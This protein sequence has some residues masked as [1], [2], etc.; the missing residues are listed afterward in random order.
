[1][2][3]APDKD[4]PLNPFPHYR[5]MRESA[6]VFHDEQSGSWHVFRYDDVQRVL[7]EH[8]LFSSRMGGD[9]PSETGQLFAASLISTDPPRHRQLRSLV[10]QA[11]TP[12]AVEALAPRIS[13][14]TEELL[15]GIASTGTADLIE[16]LAYPLPVIVIAELMGIPA[17]D[18]NRFKL[19]SD[20]IVSQ[21]R[22]GAEDA[23]HATNREMTEYFLA[24][25]ERRRSR[26]GND[27]ISNLLAAE[28]EGQKLSVAELLGFCSLLLVAGNE[29][30]THLIGNAVLC[31]TEAPGTIERL[32]AD[33]ALLPQAIEEVLR[34][35]SPVQSMYRVTAAATTLGG[36]PVPAG[37]PLVAWI[38]SANRDERQFQRPDLF[39]IHR[40]PTRHLA[41]GQGIHFCLGAP[42]AR[43]EARIA[44]T[45]ALSRLPGLELTAGTRLERMDST[46]IYGLKELPVRW[47]AA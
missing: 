25:I 1:M 17:E 21:T 6:P 39:D 42:L 36:V 41:F 45:A 26:P 3:F 10:T 47:Q 29:T 8:A 34:F 23:D 27:L 5:R 46:I 24:M 43:L 32:L 16:E 4:H 14:L 20:A 9:D 2:D 19:W 28:I 37:A 35:R 7:T 12:R 40:G 18:R 44:L 33:P 22:G 11:F 13:T 38:G 15:D 31:F 30:T